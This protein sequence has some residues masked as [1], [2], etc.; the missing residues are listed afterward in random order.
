LKLDLHVHT[1]KSSDAYTRLDQLLPNIRRSGLDGLAITDHN[2]LSTDTIEKALI[3]PGIETSSRD[4]HIIGIGVP[5]LVPR[6]LSADETIQRIRQLGGV[7][8]VAHPYDMY[9]SAINPEKLTVMPDAIEVINSASMFHSITWKKAR[10][11]AERNHL[12]QTAGS[13]S[14]IPETIG[15][16]YT[17]I[18]CEDIT[19]A[20]VLDGIKNGSTTPNGLPY[21]L[22]DRM[23]KLIRRK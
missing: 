20:S 1:N 9:R 7:S 17:T 19:I 5:N 13:D 18:D 16:A 15:K 23:R 21:T 12:P 2:I 8:I 11:F 22:G 10:E 6:G 3:I 4:G 14:H